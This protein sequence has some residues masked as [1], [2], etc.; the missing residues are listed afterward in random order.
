MTLRTIIEER[1]PGVHWRT[2]QRAFERVIPDALRGH[3]TLL[4]D[5]EPIDIRRLQSDMEMTPSSRTWRAILAELGH[6]RTGADFERALRER[7]IRIVEDAV[8][9][10]PDM[11]REARTTPVLDLA[12][13]PVTARLSSSGVACE[14]ARYVA[15][16]GDARGILLVASFDP[17]TGIVL[18]I[19]RWRYPGGGRGDM[20]WRERSIED[21]AEG[22]LRDP[23]RDHDVTF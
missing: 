10:I 9:L 20:S 22:W 13:V 17:E 11:Q 19:E 15:G 14:A 7:I 18:A 3:V 12:H 2:V 16:E 23:W 8:S 6:P 21:F 4:D 5:I 1:A